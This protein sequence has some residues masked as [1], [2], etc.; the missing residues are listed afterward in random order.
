MLDEKALRRP[1]FAPESNPVV[2]D[3][4]QTWY[5]PKPMVSLRPQ[6]SG[7][8]SAGLAART[9]FGSE[10]DGLLS[11]IDTS[12]E[13]EEYHLPE[14]VNDC[15]NVGAFLLLRNYDLTDD[16]LISLF[17][18]RYGEDSDRSDTMIAGIMN[19]ARGRGSKAGGDG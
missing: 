17:A 14:Y 12:S 18:W 8:K 15:M 3:D 9:T 10:L 5:L 7:G 19:T 11:K 16:D 2:L 4:G 6:F 1:E 13:A